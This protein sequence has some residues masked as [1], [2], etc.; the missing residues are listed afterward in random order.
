MSAWWFAA[1]I[2]ALGLLTDKRVPLPSPLAEWRRFLPSFKWLL[3]IGFIGFVGLREVVNA[4]INERLTKDTAV[5]AGTAFIVCA[6]AL[7][8]QPWRRGR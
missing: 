8:K 5:F 1:L 4:A 3:I 7:Y 2:V 6:A